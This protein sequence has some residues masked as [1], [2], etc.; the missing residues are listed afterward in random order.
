MKETLE[1]LRNDYKEKFTAYVK[2]AEIVENID[3][4]IF[5]QIMKK[6]AGCK[7]MID[8]YNE[9]LANFKET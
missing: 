5:M 3:N 2:A 8:A 9:R 7:M 6:A 4:E 1:K